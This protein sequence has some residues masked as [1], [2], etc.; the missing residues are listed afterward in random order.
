[1][2]TK[3]KVVVESRVEVVKKAL[4]IPVGTWFWGRIKERDKKE[5]L[6][7]RV[8]GAVVLMEEDGEE[9]PVGSKVWTRLGEEWEL[10]FE[11]YR[12]CEGVVVGVR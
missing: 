6:Y 9:W 11:G 8:E 1:M 12:E 10:E 2:A 7:W 3:L 5:R 4:E